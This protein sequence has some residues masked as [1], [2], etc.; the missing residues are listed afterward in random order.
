MAVGTY[1]GPNGAI[2][3][4]TN[5]G[6]TWT[7]ETIAAPMGGNADGRSFGNR[8]MVDPNNTSILYFGSR[9]T[10]LWKSANAGVTWATVASFPVKGTSPFGLPF[11]VFD[12]KKRDAGRRFVNDLCRRGGHYR[13]NEPLSVKDAGATWTLVAGTTPPSALMPNHGVIASDGPCGLR[14]P[15]ARARAMPPP[16]RF[17]N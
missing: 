14:I 12:K 8:M 10:G 2:I 4:S 9:T 17:G 15:M 6:A 5:R 1:L 16:V 7:F 13:G 11:V 3:K